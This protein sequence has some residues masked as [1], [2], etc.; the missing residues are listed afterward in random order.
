M[1]WRPGSWMTRGSP[2]RELIRW[3]SPAN[4][5]G[6]WASRELPR[7]GE[8]VAGHRRSKHSRSVPA[9][10][11]GGVG[12]RRAAAQASWRAHRDSLPDQAGH[13]ARTDPFAGEPGGAAWR[14]A[15]RCRLW[16][17]QWLS[18]W[19]RIHGSVLRGWHPV[20]HYALASRDAAAAAPTW[21]KNGPSAKSIA[22]GRKASAA[23][24]E[25]TCPVPERRRLAQ[26]EL[27]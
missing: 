18:R 4:T 24:C 3:E 27:A 21:R 10:S 19:A 14:G 17:R 8:R 7:S 12:K 9:L 20:L 2:R 15:G 6:S 22:E 23:D 13:C 11:S 1:H 25:R 5:A 16:Q 26:G